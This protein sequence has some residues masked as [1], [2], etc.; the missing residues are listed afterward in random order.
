MMMIINWRWGRSKQ[1]HSLAGNSCIIHSFK[2]VVLEEAYEY[3]P[4][5]REYNFIH[6]L[7]LLHL[8][9]FLSYHPTHECS[10]YRQYLNEQLCLTAAESGY[11]TS[12]SFQH[13]GVQLHFSP[14]YTP[15]VCK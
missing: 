10:C 6:K 12:N 14:S 9:D 7:T 1:R 11:R 3:I 8:F 2:K 15:I 4:R 5:I 13:L